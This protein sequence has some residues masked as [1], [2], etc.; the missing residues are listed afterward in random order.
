M[1]ADI[2]R[3][4]WLSLRESGTLEGKSTAEKSVLFQATNID[5]PLFHQAEGPCGTG[6][7][8]D[9]GAPVRPKAPAFAA[10]GCR[11]WPAAVARRGRMSWKQGFFDPVNRVFALKWVDYDP[12]R[13]IG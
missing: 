11:F 9:R 8:P 13:P 1:L 7:F 6:G 4:S 12:I 10:A 3:D 5:F 2:I